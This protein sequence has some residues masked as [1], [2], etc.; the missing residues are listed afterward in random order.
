ME[1]DNEWAFQA[2][3]KKKTCCDISAHL[4]IALTLWRH[5]W[6]QH[7][8]SSARSSQIHCFNVLL[9]SKDLRTSTLDQPLVTW[10]YIYIL[11]LSCHLSHPVFPGML[12]CSRYSKW[13]YFEANYQT[14]VISK[15]K[16][17]DMCHTS[18]S[19]L[20]NHFIKGNF[21][22][23]S[24]KPLL[25]PRPP[26]CRCFQAHIELIHSQNDQMIVLLITQRDKILYTL[27]TDPISPHS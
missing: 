7:P 22:P 8:T 13:S 17:S 11:S 18:A 3:V 26:V 9:S 2:K 27:C 15:Q 21:D 16:N 10:E 24:S 25:T 14:P 5:C 20:S 4:S 23:S 1:Q 12:C 19:L 6:T